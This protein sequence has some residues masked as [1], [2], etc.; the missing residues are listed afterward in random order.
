MEP[1]PPQVRETPKIAPWPQA[2]AATFLPGL[3]LETETFWGLGV[4]SPGQPARGHVRLSRVA[5]SLGRKSRPRAG[6]SWASHR[7][8]R[9][10]RLQRHVQ[11]RRAAQFPASSLLPQEQAWIVL[12]L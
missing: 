5:S 3:G 4:E 12:V 9:G 10:T 8:A 1:G 2:G 6:T 11:K 7:W